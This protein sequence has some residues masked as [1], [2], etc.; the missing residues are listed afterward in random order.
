M[1]DAR[2]DMLAG[3]AGERAPLGL[4]LPWGCVYVCIVNCKLRGGC[5]GVGGEIT[6]NTDAPPARSQAFDV[7]A[8][9]RI[10][11]KQLLYIRDSHAKN[12]EHPRCKSVRTALANF[13]FKAEP[14]VSRL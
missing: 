8:A 7:S 2:R 12:R 3:M 4:G 10:R 9:F 5:C 6:R 11:S 1:P 14:K 13:S